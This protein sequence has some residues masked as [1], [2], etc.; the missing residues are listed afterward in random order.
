MSNTADNGA[1]GFSDRTSSGRRAV[2]WILAGMLVLL[3]FALVAV[4]GLL[5]RVADRDAI[6]DLVAEETIESDIITE[7]ELVD[8]LFAG[9]WWGGLG[10][11][12][13]GGTMILIGIAFGIGRR[14]IDRAGASAD[15][16]TL[17]ANALL[18]AFVTAITSFVPFSSILGG[19]VAGYLQTEDS[20]SGALV[21]AF[22]GILLALPLAIV[23]AMILFGLAIEGLPIFVLMGLIG[24][25]FAL[26][27][28]VGLSAIGGAVGAY[29]RRN[30]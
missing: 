7:A 16:P 8:F 14:R 3:G 10:I 21:G 23:A 5:H 12:L 17:R 26:A 6:A 4:G 18:G 11:I 19:G 1:G 30:H 25:L 27:F 20:W 13:A 24:L 22:A 2:D 29:I 15:P 9:S 28:T